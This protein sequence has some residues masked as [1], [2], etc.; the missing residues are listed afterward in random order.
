VIPYKVANLLNIGTIAY[1][2]ASILTIGFSLRYKS[3]GLCVIVTK[4]SSFKGS[5][6]TSKSLCLLLSSIVAS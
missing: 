4:A 6:L 1:L 2:L 5:T 3:E